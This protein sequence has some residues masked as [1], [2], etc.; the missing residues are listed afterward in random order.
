MSANEYRKF[1]PLMAGNPCV[2]DPCG[3][4]GGQLR[5]GDET[6]LVPTGEHRPSRTVTA[7]LCH[8]EC[9]RQA[10][11]QLAH[12]REEARMAVTTTALAELIAAFLA[13]QESLG[14]KVFQV[15]PPNG[16][17]R[18]AAT[19]RLRAGAREFRLRCLEG[20]SA[21]WT[22]PALAVDPA[23]HFHTLYLRSA[24]ISD[25]LM[26]LAAGREQILR[27]GVFSELVGAVAELSNLSGRMTARLEGIRRDFPE[28]WELWQQAVQYEPTQK[29][30]E[31]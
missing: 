14:E 16:T 18:K 15:E 27:H 1:P 13:A 10:L 19:V 24:A 30:M 6:T 5:A 12:E 29:D 25:A 7:A 28:V 20:A 3:L 8:W 21:D 2:G 11:D 22:A 31:D 26:R 23:N 9:V 17:D 4:C